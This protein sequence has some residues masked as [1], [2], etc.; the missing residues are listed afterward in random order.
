MDIIS[1]ELGPGN[2]V[3]DEI[4]NFI[5]ENKWEEALIIGAIG[6]F[7][8]ITLANPISTR[9]P[10]EIKKT[11]YEKPL[12]CLSFTGEIKSI[13]SISDDLRALYKK[14]NMDLFIHIHASCSYGDGQVV[15][16]GLH[17]AKVFRGLRLFLVKI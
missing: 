8:E 1:L 2:N 16:G 11:K 3:K 6:S 5:K 17:Q 9:L 14:E 7:Q 10:I 13:D 12:E 15:G 4:Y